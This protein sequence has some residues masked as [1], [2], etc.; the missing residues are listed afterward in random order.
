MHWDR[1]H[2]KNTFLIFHP[3]SPTTGVSSWNL[4]VRFSAHDIAIWIAVFLVE[5]TLD[6]PAS[7]V[8]QAAHVGIPW[9]ADTKHSSLTGSVHPVRL[10]LSELKPHE[11]RTDT[12]PVDHIWD[13]NRRMVFSDPVVPES[14]W[15]HCASQAAVRSTP[16]Q[17]QGHRVLQPE[18]RCFAGRGCFFG[19]HA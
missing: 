4:S 7:Y 9:R 12:D 18:R 14:V 19:D 17:F 6:L 8:E 11:R 13:V 1:R 2:Q 5:I 10:P 16:L 15:F 3:A